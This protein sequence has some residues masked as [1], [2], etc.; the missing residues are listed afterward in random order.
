VAVVIPAIMPG[1]RLFGQRVSE[2]HRALQTQ[3][4]PEV[5]FIGVSESRLIFPQ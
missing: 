1:K 5:G 2:R 4:Y 3:P